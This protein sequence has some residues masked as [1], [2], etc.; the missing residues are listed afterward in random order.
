MIDWNDLYEKF[1]NKQLGRDQLEIIKKGVADDYN[2]NPDLQRLVQGVGD[3]YQDLKTVEGEEKYN[4]LN[5][6]TA[7]TLRAMEGAGWLADQTAGRFLK[8]TIHNTLRV[9]PNVAEIG[10]QG[11]Q[12]FAAPKAIS[13]GIG[14]LNKS[15]ASP[16]AH[17]LAY[18]AGQSARRLKDRLGSVP[19]TAY[20]DAIGIFELSSKEFNELSK[21]SKQP[22]INSLTL[23]RRFQLQKKA[24]ERKYGKGPNSDLQM[25]A[26]PPTNPDD[27]I[28]IEDDKE[29]LQ[30]KTPTEAERELRI[31]RFVNDLAFTV[32]KVKRDG[33]IVPTHISKL[34]PKGSGYAFLG[35]A[36]A[37]WN[38]W[39]K[40]TGFIRELSDRKMTA[41][42]EH[43]VGKDKY[44]DVFWNLPNEQRFRKGSR[45]GPDNVR[46]LLDNRMKTFKD[47]SE[48]ILK[49]L[50][51]KPTKNNLLVFDYDIKRNANESIVY[52]TS[53]DDLVLKRVDG[54]VVGRLGD[55]HDVLYAPYQELK[56]G[57]SENIDKTTGRPFITTK[58]PDGTPLDEFDIKAQISI[59]RSKIIRD[60]IQFIIDEAPTLKGMTKKQKF[61]YQGSAIQ[62]DMV[63]FLDKY[64]D[65]LQPA[66]R[67][68]AKLKKEGW[69]RKYGGIQSEDEKVD[70]EFLTKEEARKRKLA[71]RRTK[72]LLRSLFGGERIDE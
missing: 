28:N 54:T 46:I 30:R 35:K 25:M 36:K 37:E 39:A 19:T 4:P 24:L 45:H 43:L 47:S 32:D 16:Q 68:R 11:V 56:K 21:L 57:L 64:K 26:T 70:S 2:S 72:S 3:F 58:L 34:Q 13:K 50:L 62:E 31:N 67:L 63:D 33:S 65:I 22:G 5:Y 51:P 15:I 49:K 9:D 17:N 55:Y 71:N 61:Q 59:W 6:L 18:K 27:I 40:R 8:D 44:Y 38:Q 48:T 7:G 66:K 10:S 12:M 1:K 53:P 60:K 14:L 23:A 52:N 42:V 69:D 20:D 41:Y 29:P